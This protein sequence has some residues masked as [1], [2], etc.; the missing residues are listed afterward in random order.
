MSTADVEGKVEGQTDD[1][2]AAVENEA[3]VKQRL[4][5]EVK[6]DSPSACE[7][8]VVV[9][10][11]KEDVDRYLKDAFNELMPKAE[12]PGF[13]PGRAPRKLVESRF[14]EHIADQVKG[15][16]LMDSLSQMSDDHQFTAIS[17]PDFD[18]N[19]VQMPDD[20]PMVFEFDIEVRPEFELPRW[21][22][23]TLERP[24]KDYSDDEVQQRLSQLL[25]KY[26]QLEAHEGPIEAGHF[27]TMTLRAS[28]EGRQIAQLT[29]ETIEVRP[30]LSLTDAKLEGF[31]K[32]LVG[33]QVGDTVTTRLTISPE[34]ESEE[35]RGKQIDLS[36]EIVAVEHRKLPELTREFLDRIGG[37]ENEAEL[38]AEVR[39]EMERQLKY[40]QQRRIREQITTQLTVTAT[41]D[42]PQDLLRRQ[43]RRELERAL[44]EL[45]SSGFSNDQIRAYM[46]E[47]HQNAMASTA[48]A[49]KE[50]FILERIAEDEKIEAQPDDYDAEIELIADQTDET[51]RRVRARLEKKGLMDTLR[52]QIV[53]R[54]VIQLIEQNAEIREVPYTPA[55]DQVVA[56]N[57]S[58]AGS[59][60][61][62]IPEAEHDE[63]INP[64]TVGKTKD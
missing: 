31:D 32:L 36:L 25:S 13:R 48:R 39:K 38:N 54:K 21:K 58:A 7:R 51:P 28:H 42:L 46:N 26:G 19:S 44:M 64:A 47:L 33:R 18:V 8:H 30:T 56:V 10:V 41:W 57:W 27:V 63:G 4:N 61:G 52:N 62:A 20:G 34:S 55:R 1:Q 2:A 11:G 14:K 37:F 24:N 9:T 40:F 16:I 53:E 59:A 45:Q 43:A 22:G 50:H 60:K 17:E 5:L 15:K 12:L 6:I 49:L 3:E 29:E 35:F 23:L